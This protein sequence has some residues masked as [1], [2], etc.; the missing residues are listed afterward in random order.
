MAVRYLGNGARLLNSKETSDGQGHIVLAS[1]KGEYVTWFQ[2]P[3]G[4]LGIGH[5]FKLE[6]EAAYDFVMRD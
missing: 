5:Y 3:T 1:W 6:C 2:A 4:E